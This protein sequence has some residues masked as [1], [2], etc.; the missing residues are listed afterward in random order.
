MTMVYKKSMITEPAVRSGTALDTV[1]TM[2]GQAFHHLRDT[3]GTVA[4][5][6]PRTRRLGP[7]RHRLDLLRDLCEPA[8][9]ALVTEWLASDRLRPG[10][11]RHYADD[12]RHWAAVAR[13]L[14]NT[15][16]FRLDVITPGVIPV[17]RQWAASPLQGHSP[18]TVNRR[19]ASLNSLVEFAK[20]RTRQPLVSPV[21]K[22]DR[23]PVD[24]HDA[25]TATPILELDEFQR[26]VEAAS[27]PHEALVPA[28][29][30]TVAGRVSECCAAD[31]RD[32]RN[33]G[34][35]RKLDLRRKGGKGSSFALPPILCDLV[36]AVA[37]GRTEGPI[38]VTPEGTPLD[39]HGVDRLLNRLGREAGVL[40][41]RDLT[42]HVLRASR[43]THMYDNGVDNDE[44]RR[45]ADHAHMST[46]MRYIRR[47]DDD[48]LKARHAG[49]AAQVYGSLVERWVGPA[50][51]RR[52]K[53]K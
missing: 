26:V 11:K 42:P 53:E 38:L 24:L 32:I 10:S 2:A 48:L 14:C 34:N 37:S 23:S 21:S 39:R 46:T 28:L 36:D 25:T 17:W 40:P 7:R 31:L 1:P 49:Q 33:T 3:L 44:I 13:D 22:Y 8:T 45:F 9:F 43:L 29:I 27:S 20:F 19:L 30:Y 52:T 6:D 50:R 16:P 47:R 12:I 18:R 5:R 51:T 35:Q 4:P 15:E 41:G